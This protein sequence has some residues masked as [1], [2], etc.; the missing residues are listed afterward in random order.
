MRVTYFTI[1]PLSGAANGGMMSCRNNLERLNSDPGIECTALVASPAALASETL[2][3]FQS[4]DIRG[5]FI[6]FKEVQ[7][8][9]DG[10]PARDDLPS[11]SR[12]WPF[13]HEIEG[14]EQSHIDDALRTHL[15]INPPDVV[16]VDYLPCAAYV[17]RLY[18]AGVPVV[19]I[20]LNRE[21]DFYED[22]VRIGAAFYGKPANEVAA[23]RLR[24]F[25]E[26][27]HSRSAAVVAIGRYDLPNGS[28]CPSFWLPPYLDPAGQ[29]WAFSDSNSLFFAGNRGHYP[30][31]LA[32]EWIATKFAPELWRVDHSVKILIVGASAEEVP[33]DWASPNIVFLGAGDS[34]IVQQLFRTAGMLLA[35]IENNFGAKFKIAEA[36][37]FGT[38]L[39]ATKAAMSGVSFLPWL[40]EL[41]LDQPAQA[42]RLACSLLRDRAALEN[43]SKRIRSEAENDILSRQGEWSRVLASTLTGAKAPRLGV[44]HRRNDLDIPTDFTHMLHLLRTR[45]LQ[46]TTQINGTML[47]VGC[48]GLEYFQW[49]EENLGKPDLHIGLEF[50]VPKPDA[51]PSNV[52]WIANTAGDMRDVAT[53]SVDLAFAG[54]TVEHLWFE[55][56][57][58]FFIESARVV[59]PGGR[60]LFD[61]PNRTVS[62]ALRWNHPEHTIEL[63]PEEANRLAELAGFDVTKCVGHWLCKGGGKTLPLT[64]IVETGEWSAE[65]RISEGD[66]E[67]CFS[68]W[69]EAVRSS[70]EADVIGI[71]SFARELSQR[72]FADRIAKMMQSQLP[73][74][75]GWAHAPMGWQGALVY[76]PYAPMPAGDWLIRFRL[77]AYGA[78]ASPGKA[79][80]FQ[81]DKGLVVA[82]TPLPVRFDGGWIDVVMKTD[83]TLFGLEMRLWSNGQAALSAMVGVEA[84]KGGIA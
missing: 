29:P 81:T 44:R 48:N 58:G 57:A 43:M 41:H 34:A 53:N 3:Y 76:G 16:V 72:H 35:P 78:D 8:G 33:E 59:K 11:A 79:E 14:W 49:I 52:Q 28:S 26:R 18:H 71:F 73:I 12:M 37:A 23:A 54:Q 19:T 10:M 38:P 25:E 75:D 63:T 24:K 30:N 51:L 40:P 27:T 4:K 39:L 70:R 50:Y 74:Q 1:V 47:S 56:L 20:T 9:P 62:N 22:L 32:I 36:I 67:D 82:E 77:D 65:R 60:L 66:P 13:P 17:P 45:E 15:E 84:Y 46:A 7:R 5:T 42:A 55:E 6:P 80:V 64:E 2:T 31:G 68:W 83:A 61:S 21:A 69:I